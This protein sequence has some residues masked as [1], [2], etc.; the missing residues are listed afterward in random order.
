MQDSDL[1]RHHFCFLV[2]DIKVIG[3]QELVL[4]SPPKAARRFV[5]FAPNIDDEIC[6]RLRCCR[7]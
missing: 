7:I 5:T 4:S 1:R 2:F 6:F 3:F